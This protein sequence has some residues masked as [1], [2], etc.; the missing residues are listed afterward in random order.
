MCGDLWTW[1]CGEGILSI[2]VMGIGEVFG[3][4]VVNRGVVRGVVSHLICTGCKSSWC[5]GCR[6]Q[7]WCWEPEKCTADLPVGSGRL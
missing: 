2:R 4:P 6:L 1:V 3:K 5:I 7:T